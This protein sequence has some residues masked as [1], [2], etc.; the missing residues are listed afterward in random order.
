MLLK[1]KVFPA[2][3]WPHN[4]YVSSKAILFRLF[5]ITQILPDS[6]RNEIMPLSQRSWR[7]MCKNFFFI[8]LLQFCHLS[9]LTSFLY[10]PISDV[11]MI[12]HKLKRETWQCY[13]VLFS[14]LPSKQHTLLPYLLYCGFSLNGRM[15]FNVPS[16]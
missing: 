11:S 12:L 14:F 1:W 7:I 9:F 13:I 5:Y 8:P 2:H 6:F 10:Y 4:T 3:R 16:Q 15:Y